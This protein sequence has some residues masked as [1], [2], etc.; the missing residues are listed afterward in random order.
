MAHLGLSTTTN[1]QERLELGFELRVR[2][3]HRL[4]NSEFQTDGSMNLDERS[5]KDF[6]LHFGI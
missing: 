2:R 4:A 5:P 1:I 6:K 3:F